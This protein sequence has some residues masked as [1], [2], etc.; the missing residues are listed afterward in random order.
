MNEVKI[1]SWKNSIDVILSTDVGIDYKE[2]YLIFKF[3]IFNNKIPLKFIYLMSYDSS[4]DYTKIVCYEKIQI[5]KIQ[6][7]NSILFQEEMENIIEYSWKYIT[8]KNSFGFRFVFTDLLKD[9]KKEDMIPKK[10]WSKEYVNLIDERHDEYN[11]SRKYEAIKKDYYILKK[12][13]ETKINEI[14]SLKKII[15]ELKK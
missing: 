11:L 13:Y 3:Y 14:N 6:N 8:S 1:G 2:L 4:N 15:E 7:L 12:E 5:K 9:F 10:P